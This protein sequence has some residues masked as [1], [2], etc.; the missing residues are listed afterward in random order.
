[1]ISIHNIIRIIFQIIIQMH[2][3]HLEKIIITQI[4]KNQPLILISSIFSPVFTK[5]ILTRSVVHL[6]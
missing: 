2:K 1:M 5:P 6:Y 4:I 3:H